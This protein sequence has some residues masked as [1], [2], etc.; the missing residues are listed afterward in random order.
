MALERIDIDTLSLNPMTMIGCE[1]WA[2]CTG[3]EGR[4]RNAMCASWGQMGSLWERADGTPHRGLPTITVFVRPQRHTREL[5]DREDYFSV[6][7]LPAEYR[8]ALAYLGAHSGRDEDK[9]AATGLTPIDLDGTTAVAEA[10]LCFVCR[11]LYAAPL[12][13]EGF[14]DRGLV[15]RNY[16][17]K[18]FHQVYVGEIIAGYANRQHA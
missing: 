14:V 15:D 5:L 13:E 7:V 4:E 16:P 3:N 11:K 12:V 1:W 9:F 17:D 6:C 10:N 18:D 2:I 8:R